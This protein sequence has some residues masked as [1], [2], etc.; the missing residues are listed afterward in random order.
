M[1]NIVDLVKVWLLNQ[2]KFGKLAWAIIVALAAY[3]GWG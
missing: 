3:M 1:K 2:G